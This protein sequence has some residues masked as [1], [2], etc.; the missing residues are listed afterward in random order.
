MFPSPYLHNLLADA[1]DS[2]LLRQV[3]PSR[4]RSRRPSAL[5]V[6]LGHLLGHHAKTG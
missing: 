4:G 6:V 2:E 3:R 5:R 1:H